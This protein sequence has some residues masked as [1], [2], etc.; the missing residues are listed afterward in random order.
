MKTRTG[1]PHR[2]A[3]ARRVRARAKGVSGDDA[4]ATARRE[5]AAAFR[6][7][8]RLGFHEGTCNHFSLKVPGREDRYLINPHG[9]H[10]SEMRASDLSMLDA[11]GTVIEGRYPVEPTAFFIHSRIHRANADAKCVLHTHMPYA[12]ALTMLDGARLEPCLQTCLRFYG[13][14]AYDDDY[15]GYGGLVLDTEEGDRLCRALGDK[16]V[17]MLA[18]H[19]VIV[20]APSVAEAFN[21]LYYLERAAEAQVLAMSTGRKLKLIGDNVAARTRDQFV[22]DSALYAG[23]HFAALCRI[24]DREAP[25]YAR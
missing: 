1:R 15:G 4:V 20:T 9:R 18:N 24:L 12:T 5:L 7:A 6:W 19:G 13:R 17:L 2:Q 14:I 11:D 3:T 21:D 10:F 16:R 25:D 23:L 8:A 22:K